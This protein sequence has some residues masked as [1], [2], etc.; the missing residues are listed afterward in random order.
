MPCVVVVEDERQI[1]ELVRELLEDER[2][3]V[4][5]A[6][7]GRAALELL[8]TVQAD[9]II[10]DVMMPGMTGIELCRTLSTHPTYAT[11][12]VILMSAGAE[13]V[14]RASCPYVAFL[15]KPFNIAELLDVVAR[16]APG[17]N[18]DA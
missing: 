10:S 17:S 12:P 7:T 18:P 14:S 4:C 3:E 11:I 13:S 9:L 1:A 16:H 15:Q 8:A 2:Y 6:D 5:L